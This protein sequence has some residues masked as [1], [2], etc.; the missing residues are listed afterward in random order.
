MEN[1]YLFQM[2][3]CMFLM[4]N[5]VKLPEEIALE[6]ID[7][8]KRKLC[9][10]KPN[11]GIDH[12]FFII[13]YLLLNLINTGKNKII[14]LWRTSLLMVEDQSLTVDE[15]TVKGSNTSEA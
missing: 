6:G 14:L 1:D 8:T 13:L 5:N 2:L 15:G 3:L 10:W 12:V 7:V 4:I 11:E 9:S